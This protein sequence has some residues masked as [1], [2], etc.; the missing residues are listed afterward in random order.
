MSAHGP[1]PLRWGL[2]VFLVAFAVW[3]PSIANDFAWDDVNNLV[4]S[5]RLKSA[6][7]IFESFAHDAM[8]SANLPQAPVG[9]YRPLALASFALD[10]LLFGPAPWGYHLASV[11]W[12]AL[13]ATAFF[14]ALRAL[15]RG[16][17]VTVLAAALTAMVWAV[18]PT[19]VEAVAWING[20]SDIFVML[21]GA[22]A[23]VAACTPWRAAVRGAVVG[24]ALF[25]ALLGKESALAWIVL[26]PLLVGLA[27]AP[28]RCV[29]FDWATATGGGIALIAW[30]AVRAAVLE[31]GPVTGVALDLD[32]FTAAP[33]VL[34]RALQAWCV[35]VDLS[36][37]HLFSF[38]TALTSFDRVAY[39]AA[40]LAAL[41]GLGC[42]W[43]RGHRA[44]ALWLL[45]WLVA[46]APVPLL[47]ARDW[48]GLNR[49]LYL[50]GAGLVAAASALL[51]PR[52]TQRGPQVAL[53]CGVALLLL[54]TQRAIVVWR[55]DVS[56]FTQMVEDQPDEPYGYVS[57]AVWLNRQGRY[58]D[59]AQVLDAAGHLRL[60]SATPWYL[61]ADVHALRGACDEAVRIVAERAGTHARPPYQL[62]NTGLCFERRG[63]SEVA[64]RFFRACATLHPACSAGL[65]RL[66]TR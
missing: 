11:L 3:A 22:L 7:A 6:D 66:N 29:P 39:A 50:G 25:V 49:W 4:D 18:W 10:H 1:S 31:G 62:A 34:M 19:H 51:A 59:A 46:I 64:A 35:P 58:G 13:A 63:D 54:Q 23:L 55:D 42:A 60:R 27:R 15:G 14:A 2:S 38:F 32:A 24:A 52:F 53:L 16:G 17:S 36:L 28:D 57:L 43:A 9:T 44:A 12:H 56:L 65:E 21:F 47:V 37:T 61:L 20:R 33:A 41:A 48:P 30:L 26:A 5:D 45:F 40:L 8:W